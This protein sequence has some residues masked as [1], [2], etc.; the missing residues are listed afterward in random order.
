MTKKT[1]LASVVL[2]F[3]WGFVLH[4][5]GLLL[6]E[7]GGHGVAGKIWGCGIAGVDLTY[8]GHG[9]VH[10]VAPCDSWTW[11]TVTLADWS[12]LALTTFAGALAMG[13]VH[14]TRWPL[15]A[16]TRILAS[17]LATGF[18]LG[19][20]SYA[21]SGGFHDLY[22]PARTA[23]WL[24]ARGLHALAWIPPML[25]FA[26]ASFAGAF[27]V[28]RAL[29]EHFGA[30]TRIQ[31]L[32]QAIATVGV[33]GLLYFAAFRVEWSLRADIWMRGVA[34][35]ANRIAVV[36]HEAPPFPIEKALWAVA[37]IAFVLAFTRPV[38]AAPPPASI[39]RR[40]ALFVGASAFAL[41]LAITWLVR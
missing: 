17:L 18:L 31:G 27:G 33:A 1:W 38:R 14:Q 29:R 7:V 16:L 32:F 39:P 6:H 40:H 2:L 21:T 25:L 28:T 20:L 34:Y 35:E 22:D 26:V 36:R 8:F 12:G 10:Y 5:A 15:S 13:L 30:R 4:A 24:G 11:T 41:F 23:R 19:Q 9:V 3:A 37:A